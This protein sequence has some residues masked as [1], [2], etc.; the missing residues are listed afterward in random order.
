MVL[1]N[2]ISLSLIYKLKMPFTFAHPAIVLPLNYLPK[3]WFSLTGL[4][5]G[6]MTPDF[7]YFIRMRVESHYSHSIDG[8][9]WFDLPLAILLAF[10][11]HNIVKNQLF[12]NLPELIRSRVLTFNQFN[13]NRYFKQHW[14]I[15]VISILIGTASHLFWDSFTHE[16]GYFVNHIALFHDSISISHLKIPIFKAVQHLSTFIGGLIILFAF[17]KLP[18]DNTSTK[19][20]N[21]NYWICLVLFSLIILVFR[22]AIGLN[23]K[24]YGHLVVS[25][26][27]SVL[28]SL[29]LTPLFLNLKAIAK[30]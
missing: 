10:T 2:D 7:E 21:K 4:I 12:Q 27:S 11:F 23:P 3:K 8:V 22:F 24:Q 18:K 5:I 20:V 28:F 13:W 16:H 15:V 17:S 19:P 26:I 14:I 30:N 29:I 6:S 1:I 25:V 9:F